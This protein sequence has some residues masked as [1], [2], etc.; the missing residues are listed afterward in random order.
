MKKK[1]SL[2]I[3][4]KIPSQ[5]EMKVMLCAPFFLCIL[6]GLIIMLISVVICDPFNSLLTN[7]SS[8]L[9][10]VPLIYL[11][12]NRSQARYNRLIYPTIYDYALTSINDV[13]FESVQYIA[14]LL[15][16]IENNMDAIERSEFVFK[17]KSPK[18]IETQ[19][20][21]S[22]VIGFQIF[23]DYTYLSGKLVAALNNY[24]IISRFD[25]NQ[26][27]QVVHLMNSLKELDLR[28]RK[29]DGCVTIRKKTAERYKLLSPSYGDVTLLVIPIGK[30]DHQRVVA[31]GRT[32]NNGQLLHYFNLNMGSI[33]TLASNICNYLEEIENWVKITGN[34]FVLS[35][36]YIRLRNKQTGEV[37]YL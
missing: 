36:D 13:L 21:S 17:N 18:W 26:T 25:D 33:K 24:L 3:A 7:M 4:S 35:K 8:A 6:S 5:N 30:H 34:E 12:Y 1:K 22:S 37:T 15:C 20:S 27:M 32:Y 31:I 23:K 9:L 19:L 28:S 2:V 29:Y 11:L 14:C 10:V 16:G